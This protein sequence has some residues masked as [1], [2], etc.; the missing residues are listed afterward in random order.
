MFRS[1]VTR[2]NKIAR[3]FDWTCFGLKEDIKHHEAYY[4]FLSYTIL[5]KA[6]V[7]AL[8]YHDKNRHRQLT[9]MQHSCLMTDSQAILPVSCPNYISVEWWR[10]HGH[11]K[12][13]PHLVVIY[14]FSSIKGGELTK[15]AQILGSC[16]RASC[17]KK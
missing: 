12:T 15:H 10:I 8:F 11:P 7:C 17:F 1:R 4:I 3:H 14:H 13:V 5:S 2:L 9:N 6:H 16:T